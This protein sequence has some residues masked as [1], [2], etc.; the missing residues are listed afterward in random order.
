[1]IK[2]YIVRDDNDL[3]TKVYNAEGEA[4]AEVGY[5]HCVEEVDLVDF[6]NELLE[7]MTNK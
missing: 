4:K 5:Y 3:I 1:M 7:R 6:L 2:L